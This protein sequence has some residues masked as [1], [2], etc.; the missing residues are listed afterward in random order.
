MG[1]AD[2]RWKVTEEPVELPVTRA[3]AKL[4]LRVDTATEDSVVDDCIEAAVDYCEKELGLA[5]MDQQITLKLDNFPSGREIFLP[6]TNLLSVISVNYT[7]SAGANQAFTDYTVDSYM[8]PGRI[9]NNTSTWPQT[10]D[11]ANAVTIVYRAGFKSYETGLTNPVPNG[12]RQAMLMLITHWFDHR[13]SVFIGAGLA[14][15]EV[16]LSVSALLQKYRRLGV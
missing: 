13:N 11:I 8:T 12:I 7:D 3:D 9:V 16:A 5:L 1:A 10:K 15:N 4:Y 14:S 2:N 6:M